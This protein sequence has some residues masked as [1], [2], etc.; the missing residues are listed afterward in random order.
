[1]D[2]NQRTR[3]LGKEERMVDW[4]DAVEERLIAA[5]AMETATW[6]DMA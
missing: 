5:M 6:P 4:N 2:V 1:M 3:D